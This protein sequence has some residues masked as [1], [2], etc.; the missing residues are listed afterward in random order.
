MTKIWPQRGI[1]E[2]EA[3]G[4]YLFLNRGYLPTPAIIL[5]RE[6]ALNHLFNEKLSRH[7]DYD[8]LLRL[9]A[10]GAKFLMLEEPLVTVHWEDFHTSSRGL[11][12][13]KS[14]FFLQEYSKFLSD[15]AISY[16]VIQQIVL[17]LLKNRQRLAAMSIALKFVNLL[18]LKIFDYLNLTS[19]FIFSD[20]RIVSLLAKLKPQMN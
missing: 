10:S 20:S 11:N 3:L 7:Q 5:R 12:P 9:E 4:D 14:L 6:F 16:F 18:H 13:D 19:H 17:R 2:G 8:F 15:R 1:A